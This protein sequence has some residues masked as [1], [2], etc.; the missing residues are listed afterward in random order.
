MQGVDWD[1]LR[2]FLAVHRE[3]T[4]AAAGRKVGVDQTTVGRRLAVLEDRLGRLFDR[5]P[6]G[7]SLTAIGERMVPAAE[8]LERAAHDVELA[9]AGP[10]TS[11]D[12]TVRIATSEAIGVGWLARELA[13]LHSAHPGIDVELVTGTV[14]LNLLRRE[15]DLALR[16]GPRPTQQSLLARKLGEVRLWLY[17][18][19]GV[20][21]RE[22]ILYGEEMQ[23]TP[24]ARALAD[25]AG[26]RRAS[27]VCN[28]I[29]VAAELCASGWGA[30]A[31]PQWIGDERPS[32]RRLSRAPIA[33]LDLWLI[34]HPALSRSARVRA[35]IDHVERACTRVCKA[36]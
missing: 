30:A 8:A 35:V 36:T 16:P 3:G 7:F 2:Y 26:E 18:A 13:T 10:D 11:L 21:D 25:H 32:L 17:G 24:P 4:L 12:G 5:T 34:V 19:R 9:A 27:I 31:L 29:L 1:D 15:A 20:R 33:T 22:V 6:E 23:Q 14:S 28:S